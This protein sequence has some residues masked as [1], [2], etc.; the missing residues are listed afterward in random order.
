MEITDIKL[1]QTRIPA[2]S[3]DPENEDHLSRDRYEQQQQ[4]STRNRCFKI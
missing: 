3:G 2:V 1:I 4:I